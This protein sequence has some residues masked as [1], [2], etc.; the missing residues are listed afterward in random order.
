[1]STLTVEDLRTIRHEAGHTVAGF[2]VLGE[3][4]AGR[5]TRVPRENLTGCASFDLPDFENR[6]PEELAGL[7]M[8]CAVVLSVPQMI[9]S[10]ANGHSRDIERAEKCQAIAYRRAGKIADV[11][12]WRDAW[13]YQK[14]RRVHELVESRMFWRGVNALEL[15]LDAWPTLSGDVVRAVLD[16]ALA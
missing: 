16:E 8:D 4:A 14:W 1:M 12:E 2:L 15:Q 5:V 9:P 11:G 6:G 10:A 7:A 3:R 13:D